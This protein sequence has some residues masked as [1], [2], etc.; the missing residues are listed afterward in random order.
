MK[1]FVTGGA[2]YIGSHVVK[3]LGRSGHDLLVYDNLSTGHAWAVL[4]GQL[5]R[6]DLGD[7]E[8][9]DGAIADF[10]PEA[11]VHFAASIQVE[12]S[13]RRPLW[14]YRNNV[15]HSLNLLDAMLRHGVRNL[16]YSSTAA[17]YGIPERIPVTEAAPLKPINPYGAS[18]V[19]VEQV[20]RDLAR[21]EDFRYV[22]LRYFNVAGA[23]PEG[24]LGQ[25]YAEATHL[26][27]RALK[28]AKGEF[29]RL[30]VYG[31]DYP[32]PDG[33]CLRDYIHV[34][35]LADAHVLALERLAVPSPPGP[36]GAVAVDAPSSRGQGGR[37]VPGTAGEP[38][39]AAASSRN[40]GS[41]TGV[42]AGE[43]KV[44]EAADDGADGRAL[45]MNCGYGHGFSVS[46]VVAA[47]K[48]VTGVDFPVVYEG[49]RAGDPPALIA[50][51]TRLRRLTGWTPRHDDLDFII[52]T[53]WD[54][55][56]KR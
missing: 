6:G 18:K 45:V 3:A 8:R 41:V 54:W 10:R 34:N 16:L 37:V 26:I 30:A 55:E 31:T 48:R 22:A 20:L 36:T 49:R 12:E 56:R 47:A 51:S 43:G 32:T 39:R 17:V 28:T 7:R 23:D 27:T 40:D 21:A 50:D 25:A 52:R 42:R 33:T 1:I 35:D 53:A 13:T 15:V 14:Y 38:G 44:P 19:M 5:I 11:V 2:G 4:A 46:E 24:Q 29:P 9:L